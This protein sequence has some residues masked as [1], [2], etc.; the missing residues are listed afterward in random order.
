[1]AV[2]KRRVD[3]LAC[4]ILDGIDRV[5]DLL[6]W[7]NAEDAAT[8]RPWNVTPRTILKYRKRAY[9]V[10]S[11]EAREDK[12]T[13][14]ARQL[15]IRRRLYSTAVS[16]ANVPAALAVVKDES[17]L[18]GLYPDKGGAAG[19][20]IGNINVIAASVQ[21]AIAD[22]RYIAWLESQPPEAIGD[23]ANVPAIPNPTVNPLT[24]E[25]E[26]DDLPSCDE[27]DADAIDHI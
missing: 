9:Q 13:H 8:G 27:Q 17:E 10:I 11:D 5:S 18:L 2:T 19:T 12:A 3:L 22:P 25:K 1:M 21:Q 24:V 6:A 7:T 15:G 20:H 23:A 14:M 26:P 4:A 16:Q